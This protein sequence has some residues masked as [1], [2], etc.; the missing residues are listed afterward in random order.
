MV[1]HRIHS[2]INQVHCI[3]LRCNKLEIL[4]NSVNP[5]GEFCTLMFYIRNNL[6]S[7]NTYQVLKQG[8]VLI[9]LPWL[10]ATALQFSPGKQWAS[11]CDAGK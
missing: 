8:L 1:P 10:T 6:N 2:W 3:A 5:R 7:S 11:F 9:V 4:H